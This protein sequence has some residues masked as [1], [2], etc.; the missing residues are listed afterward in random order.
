MNLSKENQTGRFGKEAKKAKKKPKIKRSKW[1]FKYEDSI[2]TVAVKNFQ[3][4]VRLRDCSNDGWGNCITCGE[5]IR[6]NGCD[7]GH[8]R[9]RRWK[10]TLFNEKNCNAQCKHCNDKRGLSGNMGRYVITIDEKY[11]AGTGE[12]L[13]S[14]ERIIVH[15]KR[16][17][18]IALNEYYLKKCRDLKKVN[19]YG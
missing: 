18:F 11:G 4:F 12:H 6:W 15:R 14:I 8:F 13:K 1:E 5:P 3:R 9:S 10:N 17:A 16:N 7:A 19:I 2:E